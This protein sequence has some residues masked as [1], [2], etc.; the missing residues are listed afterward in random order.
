MGIAHRD[1]NFVEHVVLDLIKA[2]TSPNLQHFLRQWFDRMDDLGIGE[3]DIEE[4]QAVTPLRRIR[5][6]R[7]L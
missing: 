6:A 4:M 3:V 1:Q 2:L 7:A 5:L